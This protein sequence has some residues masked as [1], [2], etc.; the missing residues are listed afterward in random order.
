MTKHQPI[1]II[2]MI[3]YITNCFWSGHTRKPVKLQINNTDVM[4]MYCCKCYKIFKIDKK[5]L[6][7]AKEQ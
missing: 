2:R 7:K 1:L 5:M 4:A 6:A 3:L